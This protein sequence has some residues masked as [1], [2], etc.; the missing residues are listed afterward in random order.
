MMMNNKKIIK[1]PQFIIGL[2]ILFII[3]LLIDIT[4]RWQASDSAEDII[5]AKFVCAGGKTIKSQFHNG[6]INWVELN[7][8]DGRTKYLPQALSASGARYAD[9]QDSFVFWTKGESAFITEEDLETY[10]NCQAE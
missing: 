4:W 7:L 10:T 9:P 1:S 2:L 6:K 3:L 8:S 5:S